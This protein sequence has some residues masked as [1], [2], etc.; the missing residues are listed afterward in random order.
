MTSN[1][2]LPH[3]KG[4]LIQNDCVL[5]SIE[6][7]LNKNRSTIFLHSSTFVT[8]VL[9]SCQRGSLPE[10]ISTW[11]S[12]SEELLFCGKFFLLR[13]GQ[14]SSNYLRIDD[15]T[16]FI[17]GHTGFNS[18]NSLWL[19]SERRFQMRFS[20]QE[21]RGLAGLHCGLTAFTGTGLFAFPKSNISFYDFYTL[22]VVYL[23]WWSPRFAY[24][25]W[26]AFSRS[27]GGPVCSPVCSP[28][29]NWVLKRI[30]PWLE[31]QRGESDW[32]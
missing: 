6:H 14:S 5:Q 2:Q 25:N 21:L 27:H 12:L 9:W 30:L 22:T 18:S 24:A 16:L 15:N 29:G 20:L 26:P 23:E 1:G 3:S 19:Q 11:E 13:D 10:R 7:T 4:V 31:D 32:P 28:V 8:K 17:A